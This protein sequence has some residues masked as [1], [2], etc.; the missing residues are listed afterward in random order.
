MMS[1]KRQFLSTLRLFWVGVTTTLGLLGLTLAFQNSIHCSIGAPV[2]KPLLDPLWM[3]TTKNEED[4]AQKFLDRAAQLR[5]E[6]AQAEGKTLQQVQD[7]AKRKKDDE[8]RRIEQADRQRD[9]VK[10]QHNQSK[11]P[12]SY[13]VQVPITVDDMVRQA[14]RAVER[15][16]QDGIT[17][18]TVRFN[19]V[20]ENQSATEENEWPGGAR[21]MYR[22][23]GK[24]LT[25]ALLRE[26][27]APT[28]KVDE[29][30]QERRLAPTV[31]A[32]D[33]WDFD[34][35]ALHT[36][37]A[38]EGA[39]ADIQALVFPNTD[40]KY[41]DD[42]SKISEAMGSRLFLLVNPFW[43]NVDSWSFNLLAPGAKRKAQE[44]VFDQGFNETYSLMV[45]QVR[46]ENCVAVKAYPYDWQLFAFREDDYYVNQESILRLGSTKEE[47][48]SALVTELINSRPEFKDTRTMRQMKKNIQR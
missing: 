40:S 9:A 31:K 38:A 33:I 2:T 36:A 27:R 12:G 37:E 18:Q 42:I 44:V 3:V 4:E 20:T 6:I 43:R 15:A 23:A 8:K 45:F 24:P 19:L 39:S 32:Q 26:I 11:D 25:D 35:S 48:T 46:G 17:R 7:E 16:F 5:A 41:L 34:G 1:T 10:A 14:A 30:V 29:M 28:K 47:P 13:L 22:E 21:Q